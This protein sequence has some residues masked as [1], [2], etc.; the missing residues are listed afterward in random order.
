[1]ERLKTIKYVVAAVFLMVISS[2]SWAHTDSTPLEAKDMIAANDQLTVIDVRELNEYCGVDGHIPGAL[3]YPLIAGVLEAG[4]GDFAID[5]AILVVCHSGF[6]SNQ[7][8]EF[9]DAKGYLNIY[10]MTGGM[11]YWEWETVGCVDSDGDGLNDDLDNCPEH[12]NPNQEDKNQNGLGDFCD[13]HSTSCAAEKVYGEYSGEADVLRDFRDTVLSTT[14][15]GTVLIKLYYQW[16]P[17]IVR[18]MEQDKEFKEKVTE[19]LD[20]FLPMIR[21]AV[22]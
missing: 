6:R 11:S 19:V 14:S 5:D 12:Y 17:V 4:Y 15:E 7:A 3:N 13:S 16:S 2:N 18:F 9:L 1:M 22:E 10:D 21:R 8:A 20:D